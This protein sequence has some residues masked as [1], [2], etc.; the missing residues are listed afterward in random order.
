MIYTPTFYAPD[1]QPHYKYIKYVSQNH[2]LPIQTSLTGDE[3]YD[4]EYYQPPLYY[5]ML[6]PVYNLSKLL[7]LSDTNCVRLLRFCSIILWCI[8]ICMT[9]KI[10]ER[11]NIT[12]KFIKIFIISMVSLLPSYVFISSVINNDNLLIALGSIFLYFIIDDRFSIR[13]SLILGLLLGLIMLTKINGAVFVVLLLFIFGKRLI[14][15]KESSVVVTIITSLVLASIMISPWLLRNWDLYGSYTGVETLNI[16]FQWESL[17][18]AIYY[19]GLDIH[20]TFWT[21]SGIHNNVQW[22]YPRIGKIIAYLSFIGI[23]WG[24]ISK[25]ERLMN[26]LGDKIDLII[27]FAAIILINIILVFRFGFL[28]GQGQGRH[29]FGLLIPIS[30]FMAG[31]LRM[32]SFTDSKYSHIIIAGI[33]SIY[34]VSFTFYSIDKFNELMPNN[35]NPVTVTDTLSAFSPFPAFASPLNASTTIEY[36]LT[37][38][39]PVSLQL[40]DLNGRQIKTRFEGKPVGIHRT[41]LNASSLQT[42]TCL[43]RLEFA[44]NVLTR[45]VILNI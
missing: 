18:Q 22:Y 42:G 4:W 19:I 40:Y 34:A 41:M 12:D 10:I 17:K 2:S 27:A 16:R 3:T 31:G 33:M 6:S 36:G 28:Y 9:F 29:L 44:V 11:L 7:N 43:L 13:H 20:N 30:L 25:R 21:T 15:S 1:E 35:P 23:V 26:L 14:R 24:I 8:T 32:F 5:V 38:E 37:V 39:E 45:K